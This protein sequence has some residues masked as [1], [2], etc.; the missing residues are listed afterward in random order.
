MTITPAVRADPRPMI[1]PFPTPG[2]VVQLAYRELNLAANGTPQEKQ[3]IGDPANLPRPWEPATCRTPELRQQLWEWL[4]QVVIWLNHEYTWEVAS[5]IPSCWPHHPHLVH[6]IAVIADQRRRAH[7]DI[8]SNSLE[9]WHR[10]CLPAF[11]DRMRGRLKSHCDDTH[12]RWPGR[13]RHGEHTSENDA[14]ARHATFA[15][16]VDTTSRRGTTSDH[17]NPR[18]RFAVVDTDTGE[19]RHDHDQ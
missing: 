11:T 19:I 10:Y 3:Q 15:A 16:D 14:A 1:D 5:T 8:T 18:S 13:G 17:P 2:P 4:E 7:L 9:E 6:E 12:A